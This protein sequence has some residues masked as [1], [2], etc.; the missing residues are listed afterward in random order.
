A[1]GDIFIKS[2]N[3]LS[4][5]GSINNTANILKTGGTGTLTMQSQARLNSGNITAS[6]TGI[7]N[8]VLWSDYGNQN[9]GGVEVRAISTNGGHFWLGGSQSNGGSYTWKGLNV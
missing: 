2:T 4:G 8:V 3:N 9:N 1:T 5:N 7:L 6:G